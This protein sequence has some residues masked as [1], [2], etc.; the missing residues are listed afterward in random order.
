MI[1][2][3]DYR[4]DAVYSQ[5][6]VTYGKEGENMFTDRRIWP[7]KAH[8]VRT[9]ARIRADSRIS[10]SPRESTANFGPDSGL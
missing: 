8:E 6:R 4:Y 10:K 7:Q 2:G 1:P 9:L 5:G 3:D